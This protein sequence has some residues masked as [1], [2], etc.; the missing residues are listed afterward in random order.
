MDTTRLGQLAAG[1]ME[2]LAEEY[3]EVEGAEIGVVA[4]IAEVDMPAKDDDDPG[5]TS[6]Q[7]RCTDARR[8]VQSGLFIAAERGVRMSS[9]VDEEDED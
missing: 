7:Y 3:G 8:W 9:T 5:W 2:S 6:V 4:V 1:L